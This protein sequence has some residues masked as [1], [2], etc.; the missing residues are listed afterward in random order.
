MTQNRAPLPEKSTL[1]E[2]PKDERAK[3]IAQGLGSLTLQNLATSVLGFLFLSALLRLLSPVQY[4]VYSA[5]N[6][7][8]SIGSTFAMLGLNQAMARYVAFLHQRDEAQSW[9]A[10]RRI[11]ALALFFTVIVTGVYAAATPYLS[12]YFTK[13][14][15]WTGVFLLAGVYLFL[16]SLSGICLGIIQGLKRY[17]LLAKML[18]ASK[19]VM[20]LF[21]VGALF[22]Y[23]NVSV[24]ILAWIIYST[25]I[26]AWTFALTARKIARESGTFSYS[27]ILRYSYPIGVAAIIGAVASSADIIVVGGYLNPISLGV[28]NAAVTISSILSAVLV[29]PL[30]TAFLP[31]VSSSSSEAEISNGLRLA[32]RFSVLVML[33]ASLFV[34]AVPS[35]LIS[36]FSGG[37]GYLAGSS[38]LELIAVFYLF[39]AI[40]MILVVLFQAVGRT[41]Y[42]MVIG[43]ATVAS[44]IGVS[45]L[46]VPRL[47][48]VGA[49]AAKVSVGVVGAVI[50]LYLARNYLKDVGKTGFY[51]KTIASALIPFLVTYDLTHLVSN[52]TVTLAPYAIVYSLVFLLCIK[53]FKLLSE[54]DKSFVSH[55]LPRSL[56]PFLRYV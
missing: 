20:V 35:Q 56:R 52:R 44:D 15:S 55:I 12:T 36:L 24:P 46:L 51:L 1:P 37:R 13:T 32:L 26:V 40:Q 8:V 6:V 9:A 43:F 23:R 4:G 27:S 45:I 21:G 11:L 3:N 41:T 38:S 30:T 14:S 5:V 33:P 31:E 29:G 50:G 17:V 53:G 16:G 10:A 49:A 48:L 47:G 28:Y 2:Q 42:V 19:V 18:F 7:S 22:L 54:E 39:L 34:A 25:F